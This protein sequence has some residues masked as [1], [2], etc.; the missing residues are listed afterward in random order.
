MLVA[1]RKVDISVD[2]VNPPHLTRQPVI[3]NQSVLV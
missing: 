2:P 3:R 1:S